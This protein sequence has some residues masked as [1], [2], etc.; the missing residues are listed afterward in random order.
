MRFLMKY[1]SGMQA[2]FSLFSFVFM[3]APFREKELRIQLLTMRLDQTVK[4]ICW[5]PCSVLMD[6]YFMT[7]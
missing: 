5:R 7:P 3:V 2:L 4:L 1:F 6:T